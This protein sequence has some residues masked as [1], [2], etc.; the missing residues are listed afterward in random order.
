MSINTLFGLEWSGSQKIKF[1][2]ALKAIALSFKY[3]QE[4][5]GQNGIEY[6]VCV[7]YFL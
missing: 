5:R 6:Y 3:K 4:K 7:T 2:P 1:A